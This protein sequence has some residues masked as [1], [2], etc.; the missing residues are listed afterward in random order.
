MESQEC[1]SHLSE[2][3]SLT[4]HTHIVRNT[5]IKELSERATPVHYL[6]A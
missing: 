4:M 5:K 2:H 6:I 1:S 3:V